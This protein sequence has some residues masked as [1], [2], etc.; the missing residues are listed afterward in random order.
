M[1]VAECSR[2]VWASGSATPKGRLSMLFQSTL[3][4][5]FWQKL[6]ADPSGCWLWTAYRN[7]H[8]YGRC[9]VNRRSVFAHRLA[10]EAWTGTAIPR[11][12]QIDH[13]CRVPRCCN[14]EHLEVVTPRENTLR[15][16]TL[17]AEN[18]RKTHC[19]HGHPY[20]LINTYVA[21]TRRRHCR[22]CGMLRQRLKERI[23]VRRTPEQN[24]RA[25]ELMRGYRLRRKLRGLAE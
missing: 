25:A 8:G 21:K 15:G 23:W 16:L 11:G 18:V 1:T 10:Y 22:R 17:P 13:L 2:E 24:A 19:P 12:M 7:E 3:P 14:P 6:Y 5:H 20:D 9:T 4:L